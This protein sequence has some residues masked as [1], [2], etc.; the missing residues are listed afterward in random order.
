MNISTATTWSESLIKIYLVIQQQPPNQAL[1]S[2]P[3]F[4]TEYSQQNTKST[5]FTHQSDVV[6]PLLKTLSCLP[7]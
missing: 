3:C 5:P 4:P 2:L 6:T 1:H 7:I